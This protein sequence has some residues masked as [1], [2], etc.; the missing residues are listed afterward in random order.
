[1]FLNLLDSTSTHLNGHTV[2]VHI[3]IKSEIAG[4]FFQLYPFKTDPSLY[5]IDSSSGRV[6]SILQI[7]ELNE[8][9]VLPNI[10]KVLK[11]E[12]IQLNNIIIIISEVA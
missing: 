3:E 9:C 5:F 12:V 6:V 4:Q 2:S 7:N 8:E 1:M 10:M 11:L